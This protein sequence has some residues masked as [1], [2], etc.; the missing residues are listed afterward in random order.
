MFFF[1]RQPVLNP[2]VTMELKWQ[3]LG[4]FVYS[5]SK[6]YYHKTENHTLNLPMDLILLDTGE[7]SFELCSGELLSSCHLS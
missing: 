4:L 7:T 3:S 1:L 2:A 5:S 6:G